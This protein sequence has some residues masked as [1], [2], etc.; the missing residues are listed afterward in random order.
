MGHSSWKKRIMM[1]VW[2]TAIL[3]LVVITVLSLVAAM[4][5]GEKH[6]KKQTA[7]VT[8]TEN[9]Q[10]KNDASEQVTTQPSVTEQKV[11]EQKVTEQKV[12]EQKA[13]EQK[14]AEQTTTEQKSTEQTHKAEAVAEES[15]FGKGG[16]LIPGEI[17]IPAKGGDPE[18]TWLL[19]GG[20]SY[21]LGSD[22]KPVMDRLIS[23]RGNEYYLDEDGRLTGSQKRII[24][25]RMYEISDVG[26]LAKQKGWLEIDG[27]RY[28]GTSEGVV[29][30]GKKIADSGK[31]YYLQDDGTLMTDRTVLMDNRLYQA[32]GEGVLTRKSGWAE[33]DGVWY[34][35]EADGSLA[36]SR[37]IRKDTHLWYVDEDGQVV[38]SAFYTYNDELYFADETGDMRRKEGWFRWNKR[39]YYSDSDGKFVHDEYISVEKEKYYLDS[40]GARIVGKPTIDM[41]LKCPGIY[42]W[43]TSHHTDYY[44]KTNYTS[45]KY[46]SGHPE[47]L[48]RPYGE[49][50]EDSSMN[51]TG[52]I[53]SL[54]YY[55]GGDLERVSAMGRYMGY[56]NGDNYLNLATKGYVQYEVFRSAKDLLRSGKAH[57]GDIMYLAPVWGTGDCHM[58]VFWG[59]TSSENALWSQTMKTKCTVTEIYMVDPVN[60]IYYFP[61]SRNTTIEY[62]EGDTP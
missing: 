58:G 53:S 6:E 38:T 8:A 26:I 33:V 46:H 47:E 37:Q 56:G 55:S 50:G 40:T 57:K 51:C 25:G 18:G 32:D 35:G 20:A 1:G 23:W 62:Y 34:Y 10:A 28:Y 31:E 13:T 7:A 5:S 11:T 39:W 19:S 21:Y 17:R 22:G 9:S 60:Q 36:R 61:I 15:H 24:D 48:I 16:A 52:F 3:V 27:N 54:V 45:L 49:Y 14:A 4:R 2:I 29:V 44:F 59:D 42:D 41:Y 30:T 12:T 43:M